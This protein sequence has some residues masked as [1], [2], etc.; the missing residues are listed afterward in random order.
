MLGVLDAVLQL[1]RVRGQV[2]GIHFLPPVWVVRAPLQMLNG[3]DRCRRLM[4]A[5]QL[6][7]RTRT[8]LE[9]RQTLVCSP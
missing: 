5:L 8:T 9:G 2:A 6:F 4:M 1:K 7:R 3:N